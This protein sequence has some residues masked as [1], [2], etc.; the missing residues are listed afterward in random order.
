[1]VIYRRAP[2]TTAQGPRYGVVGSIAFHMLIAAATLFSFRDFHAPA[3]THMVP[4]DLITIARNTDVAAQAPP[5]PPA[6]P[7]PEKLDI[8]T[9]PVEPPPEPQMAEPA[10]V[11]DV[12]MPDFDVAKPKPEP[13]PKPPEKPKV[14]KAQRQQQ[15][16]A[17]LLNKLTAAP[18]RPQN[19]KASDRLVQGVG[20]GNAM[21]ADLADALQSQI[22]RCWS[23]PVGAPNADDLVVEYD[24]QLNPDGTVAALSLLRGSAA[25]ASS[26]SYTRAA[27]EAASR[28][29]YQCA[30]YRL[31]ARDY[32]IWRE[33]NP[34]HFDPRQLMQQ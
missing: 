5:A 21:T 18:K 2:P 8:P 7:E 12:Q 24:L 15:D 4:V 28:A 29:I 34:L 6:P 10:P 26:N 3:E 14:S 16:F 11:P 9:P 33:I 23:P 30:P 19:A 25:A 1:V 27:A 32:S 13:K 17:A 20:A 22:Y 31:P